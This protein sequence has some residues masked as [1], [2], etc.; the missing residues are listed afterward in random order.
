L[1]S[2]C[3]QLCAFNYI[4]RFLFFI[5]VL[6]LKP[7]SIATL[8]CVHLEATLFNLSLTSIIC[9]QFLVSVPWF[10]FQ[11]SWHPRDDRFSG[12]VYI[13]MYRCFA[14]NGNLKP[15]LC[16]LNLV[17]TLCF[18]RLV[19]FLFLLYFVEAKFW[20]AFNL[21]ALISMCLQLCAFKYIVRFHFFTFVFCSSHI[22][23]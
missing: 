23:L 13:R 19:R 2:I 15:L 16:L 22:R 7:H 10:F 12:T 21:K 4:V 18:Q 17:L 6:M 1:I 11:L 3:L 5:F 14:F 8:T 20:W 9:F